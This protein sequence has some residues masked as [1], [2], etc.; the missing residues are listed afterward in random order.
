MKAVDENLGAVLAAERRH[1]IP[2]Y[3]RNYEWTLE[4]QW[5]LLCDDVFDVAESLRRAR[6]QAAASGLTVEEEEKRVGAHFL[7]ALVL[8]ALPLRGAAVTSMAVIDG[9]QRLTTVFLFLRALLDNLEEA[10]DASLG[11]RARQVRRMLLID[12]DAVATDEEVYKLWP[13][14]RDQDIWT[15]VMADRG[16][17]AGHRFHEARTYFADRIR[18]S[19]EAL[20]DAERR[21]WLEV[22]AD[23]LSHK[24][25]VV[26]VTLDHSDDSQL[27]FEVLNGRQ[28]PL[29]ATDLVKNLLFMRAGVSDP[30]LDRLY[31]R[32]WAPFDE[33]WWHKEVGRGHAARGRR[34]QLL[35]AWLTIQTND[36]VNAGRLYG[37]ARQYISGSSQPLEAM[38]ADIAALAREYRAIYER[39]DG[40]T[41]G[42]A[43]AYRRLEKLGVTTAVPLLAWLRTLPDS[44]LPDAAHERAVA[45]VDSF[46]MRRLLVSGQTR[47]YGRAFIEVLRS[48][49]A[50]VD[51]RAQSADAAIIQ[52]LREAPHG[53]EWPEDS[54]IESEFLS[55][56]YYNRISQER[57][58]MI[59]GPID[60]ALQLR[61]G[62]REFATFDYEA[63]TIE[64]IMPQ[65]WRE[66]WPV[67]AATPD[68]E[69]LA[70]TTRDHLIHRLGNLTLV[71][72]PLNSSVSNGPWASKRSELAKHSELA[73]NAPFRTDR[74]WNEE[75]IEVRARELAA[76][77]CSV[78]GRPES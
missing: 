29:S 22:L 49:R 41:P 30:D 74:P 65:Q 32:Y 21:E 2:I 23:A 66:H 59:L 36:E 9:Q 5:E 44:S 1:V 48:A 72:Q 15:S 3:Q 19:G 28:T 46:V 6:R 38:L 11:L 63:L 75:A 45:A 18:A 62:K 77:A 73:L 17:V 40:I 69:L 61:S 70:S 52:A 24:V 34:D 57:I 43:A 26:V 78:W 76:L 60:R 27:I 71:T 54:A 35:A 47:G 53:L 12:R 51:S 56:A 67:T 25:R 7:G 14:R 58:R 64:H 13:R 37:E 50:A 55:R 68:E 10:D 33:A 42:I 4:G 16:S 8:E 31:D 20:D 39:P